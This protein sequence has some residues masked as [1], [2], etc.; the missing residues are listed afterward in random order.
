[1]L[2][3]RIALASLLASAIFA[4][5]PALAVLGGAPHSVPASN[6]VASAKAAT[7]SAYS[8]Q[9]SVDSSGTHLREYINASGIV[10]A[11][12]WQGP[13]VP[14]LRSELGQYYSQVSSAARGPHTARSNTLVS[15][16]D[17]VVQSGGRPRA[18]IGRA[19]L[20]AQVPAGVNTQDIQ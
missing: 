10:F 12:A 18:F 20:P 11:L 8:V 9:E 3:A 5:L 16:A 13:R 19:W 2:T 4:P 1:M 14:D 6:L 7:S 15:N 17:L